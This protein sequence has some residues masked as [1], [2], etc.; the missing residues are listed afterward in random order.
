MS[1]LTGLNVLEFGGIG[2]APFA[3][4]V[5]A[6]WGANV[7][8][9]DRSAGRDVS[10]K[11]VTSRGK[12]S[13]VVDAKDPAGRAVLRKMVERADVLVDPYRP[14][15]LEKLGLG[16]EDCER[17]NPRL[18]YARMTG[19][20][21]ENSSYSKMA[22]HDINYIALSGVLDMIRS[23]DSVTGNPAAPLPPLNLLGDFAG[24]GIMLVLGILLAV[25]ER[26]SSGKGQVVAT[27]MVSGTRYI[28]SFPLLHANPANTSG[29]WPLPPG[30]NLLDGGS[31][32]YGLYRTSDNKYMSVGCLEPQFFAEF[33]RII[34]P[35]LGDRALNP[36]KQT[37]VST[38]PAMRKALT[39]AFVAKP[40]DEWARMFHGTDACCVPVL[41]ASEVSSDE[42]GGAAAP[43][44]G[45]HLPPAP[46]PRLLRTPAN[47]TPAYSSHDDFYVVNGSGIDSVLRDLGSALTPAETAYLKKVNGQG[48]KL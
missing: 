9:I 29:T 16:P 30:N 14:G 19:F 23:R 25:V 28:S 36:K 45:A 21:R 18:I 10:P 15:V 46:H 34:N 22:G 42:V 7:T 4:M 26:Q 47:P 32:F 24:G 3:C 44:A 37:D 40:R 43:P 17:I 48:S 5:L 12:T 2:P 31:P 33:A 13:V 39:D 35:F 27:D 1:P 8:R 20:A 41:T 11:D 38:W 6:D